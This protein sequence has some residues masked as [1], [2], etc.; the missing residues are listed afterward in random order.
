MMTGDLG[1]I[2]RSVKDAVIEPARTKLIPFLKE[3]KKEAASNGALVSFLGGSGPCIMSFYDS[4]M[5]IGGT[6]AEKVKAVYNKNNIGC[7][8]W[9]T[10]PGAGCKRL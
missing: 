1:T 9:I 7:E 3:A 4:D 6:I 8:T 5:N 2:S 10:K